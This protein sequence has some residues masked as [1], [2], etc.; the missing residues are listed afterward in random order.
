MDPGERR[1]NRRSRAL[2]GNSGAQEPA[3]LNRWHIEGL[4]PADRSEPG[5][6][7]QERDLGSRIGPA[8]PE[9]SRIDA[10][11]KP[12]PVR[13]NCQEPPAGGKNAPTFAQERSR[14]M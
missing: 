12:A 7:Q 13:H 1:R 11:P 5:V 9:R 8:L 4:A 14:I 10:G 2:P 3:T 6:T